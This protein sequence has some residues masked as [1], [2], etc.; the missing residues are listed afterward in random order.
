VT[1]QTPLSPAHPLSRW[2]TLQ[3]RATVALALALFLGITALRISGP[4]ASDADGIL[5]VLPVAVVALR[6][7]LRGGLVSGLVA[8]GLVVG[9]DVHDHHHA[10]TTQ[11]SY[12][13]RGIAFVLL[14]ALVGTFVDRRRRLERQL[15]SYYNESLDML[16][17][18]DMTGR[19]I[20][21]NPAWERT[22]GHSA[23]TMCAQPFIEFVHPDDRQATAAETASILTG[24]SQGIG[25]RNRYR[26]ADGDYRWLEWSAVGSP[27]ESVIHA[28]AR[29]V[30]VQHD[31]ETAVAVRTHELEVARRE[32]LQRLALAAEYRDDDTYQH[33]ARV[34][35]AAEEIAVA[36]GLAAAE[37]KLLAEAAPLHDI[38]KLAIPDAIL[39][40]PGALSAQEYEIM[41]T[42]AALG[43]SLL[44]GS[45]SPV[46]Q[47]ATVIAASHHERW[48]GGGYPAGLAG[49]AIPLVGRVTAVAD[50]FDVLTHD[51]PYKSAWTVE[52]AVVEIQ[53]AAGSQFDPRVVAAFLTTHERVT[54]PPDLSR[55]PVHQTRR[56]RSAP[57]AAGA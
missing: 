41:K 42:H 1:S 4:S 2:A 44:S 36:L 15:L 54:V 46:L 3:V 32:T 40:K 31:A 11:Q 9:A 26:A 35:I 56:S 39:L 13:N 16:A 37:V 52:Q 19:F 51:R 23:E 49:E 43:A 45:G 18:A 22:L 55:P 48:D 5:Y 12:L 57:A 24:S 30:T 27:S 20:R 47:V 29:D 6:F 33:T 10:L 53:R 34:G 21:V 17:T 50:V 28:V 25:F 38:G 7:G 14:G 8:L